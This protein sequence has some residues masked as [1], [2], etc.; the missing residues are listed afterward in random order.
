MSA[1][2]SARCVSAATRKQLSK[3]EEA[4]AQFLA[5]Q[6]RLEALRAQAAIDLEHL[7]ILARPPPRSGNLVD[8][9]LRGCGSF[10]VNQMPR[11][12]RALMPPR[13]AA[14]T[15]ALV[16]NAHCAKMFTGFLAIHPLLTLGRDGADWVRECCR[17]ASSCG[18]VVRCCLSLRPGEDRITACIGHARSGERTIPQRPVR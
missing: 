4:E 14:T 5:A 2:S 17:I 7:S 6:A 15:A 11:P 10:L 16:E 12:A 3:L 1:D 18:S 8:V 13:P 9:F